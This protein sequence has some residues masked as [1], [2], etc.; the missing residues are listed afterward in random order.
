LLFEKFD[1][2]LGRENVRLW[3]FDPPSFPNG[4]VVQDFCTRLGIALPRERVIRVN[5]S[6][7][8]EAVQLLYT[9]RKLGRNFGA[10]NITGPRNKSAW[11]TH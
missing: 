1:D 5:A 3:K 10:L 6:I 8:R 2:V 4:C 7:S 9:Y 11:S